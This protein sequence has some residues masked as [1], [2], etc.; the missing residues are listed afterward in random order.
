MFYLNG[1][2]F[3]RIYIYLFV[4]SFVPVSIRC[5]SR[6]ICDPCSSFDE[7]KIKRWRPSDAVLRVP[8]DRRPWASVWWR[9]VSFDLLCPIYFII[10]QPAYHDQPKDWLA[11]YLPCP[12]LPFGLL[13]LAFCYCLNLINEHDVTIYDTIL[14][15]WLCCWSCDTLGG[16]GCFLSTSP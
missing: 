12:C 16:S 1:V 5:A 15:S 11:L 13:W 7:S 14:L 3:L 4:C 8:Q 10:H 9:Q 6:I 2:M